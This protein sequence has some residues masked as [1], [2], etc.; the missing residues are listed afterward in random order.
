MAALPAPV[1][2][3]DSSAEK[4]FETL[5]RQCDDPHANFEKIK[6]RELWLR[7]EK[8]ILESKPSTQEPNANTTSD[9]AK[10]KPTP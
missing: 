1:L 10:C 9:P 6:N 7:R 4:R 5:V 8:I 3:F 2:R